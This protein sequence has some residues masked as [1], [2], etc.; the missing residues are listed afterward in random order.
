[1]VPN[2]RV[3]VIVTSSTTFTIPY[4]PF[5][6]TTTIGYCYYAGPP[7]V[8]NDF[9]DDSH[10]PKIWAREFREFLEELLGAGQA[11]FEEARQRHPLLK[12]IEQFCRSAP[13]KREWKMKLWKQNFAGV[14]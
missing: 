2:D 13:M 4:N 12:R 10:N 5:P 9:L 11:A 3:T 8:P 7:P 6:E 14:V 1:M